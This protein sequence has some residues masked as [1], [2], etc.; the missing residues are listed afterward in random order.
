MLASEAL[1]HL[2]AL[3]AGKP[4]PPEVLARLERLDLAIT[5]D[6]TD[7]RRCAELDE[8][9]SRHGVLDANALIRKIDGLTRDLRSDMHRMLSRKTTL[10]AEERD[11]GLCKR[12]LPLVKDPAENARLQAARLAYA[13]LGPDRLECLSTKGRRLLPALRA[14]VD[15]FGAEPFE[16]FLKV[17]HKSES[18]MEALK[19]DLDRLKGQLWSVERGREDV[20]IGL[21]KSGLEPDLAIK[22]WKQACAAGLPHDKS[23]E[24]AHLATATVRLAGKT[25]VTDTAQRLKDTIASLRAAG[26]PDGPV[27]RGAARAVLS[28]DGPE[29]VARFGALYHAFHAHLGDPTACLRHAGRLLSTDGQPGA[30]AQRCADIAKELGHFRIHPSAVALAT[31]VT[32]ELDQGAVVERYRAIGAALVRDGAFESPPDSI[33]DLV[34]CKGTPDEVAAVVGQFAAHLAPRA[35]KPWGTW[36]VLPLAIACARRL[37]Y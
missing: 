28:Y 6:A 10:A 36:D 31:H 15:R 17:F 21:L 19:S 26:L 22:R 14:R 13:E 29:P 35:R 24:V 3:A 23:A 5:L 1:A 9:E 2:E 16:A 12:L 8:L 25:S 30:L 4:V 34:G 18:R 7:A 32:P 11:R 20:V 33:A 27:L 37:M